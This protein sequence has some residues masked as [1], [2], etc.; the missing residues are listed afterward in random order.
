MMLKQHAI[1]DGNAEKNGRSML[2]EDISD[3]FGR[4]F[5]AAQNCRP[6]IQQRKSET[7]TEAVR[8]RQT[9][10]GKHAI[11]ITKLKNF[12]AEGFIGVEDVRLG[13]YRTLGLAGAA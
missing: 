11:T 13:V 1:H 5:F 6:P 7:V 10:R 4:R 2:S 12:A 8:E 3:D 9:R